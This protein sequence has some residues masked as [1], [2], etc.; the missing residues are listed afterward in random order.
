LIA[1]LAHWWHWSPAEAF[2]MTGSELMWWLE[3]ANR[4]AERERVQR[5]AAQPMRYR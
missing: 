3:Q 4:I 5:E 1:D 2:D